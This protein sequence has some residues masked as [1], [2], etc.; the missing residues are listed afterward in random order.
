[1][2]G[3]AKIIEKKIES[4]FREKSVGNKTSTHKESEQSGKSRGYNNYNRE[5]GNFRG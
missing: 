3:M 4:K 2:E 1:M 5:R